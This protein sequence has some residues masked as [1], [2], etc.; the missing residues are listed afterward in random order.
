MT[1]YTNA[2]ALS[3][4]TLG[5]ATSYCSEYNPELLQAVPRSLNRDGLAISAED[6]PFIGEDVWLKEYLGR[7]DV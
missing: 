3:Q 4:L 1:N 7:C 5:K 6:L 2:K